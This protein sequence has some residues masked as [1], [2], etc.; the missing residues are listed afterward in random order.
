MR[1]IRG[2]RPLLCLLGL[3]LV[4]PLAAI[5]WLYRHALAQVPEL[6]TL[7]AWEMTPDEQRRRDWWLAM[8]L[9]PG[10][11]RSNPSGPGPSPGTS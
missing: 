8:E 1:R 2:L 3:I 5:E 11:R 10:E 6:P 4:L 9:R 7:P